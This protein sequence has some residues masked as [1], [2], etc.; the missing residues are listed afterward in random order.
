MKKQIS[1]AVVG[2]AL[3]VALCLASGTTLAQSTP[4]KETQE[5]VQDSEEEGQDRKQHKRA[6][7]GNKRN[8]KEN[9]KTLGEW[10]I[11][12]GKKKPADKPRRKNPRRRDES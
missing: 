6:R 12:I 1:S 11:W 3:A 9:V 2:S 10:G 5:E 4:E 7:A 8:R